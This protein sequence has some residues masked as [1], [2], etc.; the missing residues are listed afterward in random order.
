MSER[1]ETAS[2]ADLRARL[3]EKQERVAELEARRDDLE[4]ERLTVKREYAEALV[5]R[6]TLL[7]ADELV[8]RF[9]L[10]ELRE[11]VDDVQ[12]SSAHESATLAD[13][14]PA[15]QSGDAETASLSLGER[16]RV[17]EI[18]SRLEDLPERDRGLVAHERARLE[19]ELA[20]LR[21][22]A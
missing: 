6:G 7:D 17:A 8:D 22:E 13:T 3:V 11:K 20:E 18:V 9:S 12:A 2:L 4:S 14:E 5:D 15:I 19:E 21:G 1:R 10:R 16:E